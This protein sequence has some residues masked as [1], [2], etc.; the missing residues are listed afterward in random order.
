MKLFLSIT[1]I[2]L[3]LGCSTIEKIK[4]VETKTISCCPCPDEYNFSGSQLE[5]FKTMAQNGDS[6]AAMNL[7]NHYNMCGR[8]F[9]EGD[10]WLR[11]A[12]LLKH[13]EAQ[14]WIGELIKTYDKPYNEFGATKEKALFSLFSESCAA[15]NRNACERLALLYETGSV[16]IQNLNKARESMIKCANQ[17]NRLCWDKLSEYYFFGIGGSK[18]YIESYFWISL[19]ALCVH[20]DSLGGKKIWTFRNRVAEKIENY[21]DFLKLWIKIDR[22]IDNIE[23]KKFDV[24][25]DRCLGTAVKKEEYESCLK[26]VAE[27]EDIHRNNIK[28]GISSRIE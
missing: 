2:L 27:K 22:Y 7:Y 24:Y 18:D 12:A 8:D 11:K 13:P 16:Q 17:G 21:N 3:I 19:E 26:T 10:L 20:P 5:F 4:I 23:N 9:E 14:R 1:I 28:K 6:E 25:F 15:G